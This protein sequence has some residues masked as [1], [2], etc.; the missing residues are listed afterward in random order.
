M[1]P[2]PRLCRRVS[3][4]RHRPISFAAV[5]IALGLVLA[6]CGAAASTGLKGP[7]SRASTT[8]VIEYVGGHWVPFTSAKPLSPAQWAV[9]D[10]YA[11][12]S[13]AALAV[14][15][16]RSVAPLAT[17]VSAQSKVT[18]M[19][20]RDL[21]A[22]KNPEAL[23]TKA[24]VESV[25][26]RG[27]RSK[28]TLEL[29]YPGGRSLHY[30]SSWVRP[31]DRAALAPAHAKHQIPGRTSPPGTSLAALAATQYA[32]WQFVGDNRV[33]GVDTPCGI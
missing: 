14:Y 13:S 27:C 29:Y 4:G 8:T 2:L 10:A 7:T 18:A 15:A 3:A 32:P 22:G 16:T 17:V 6:A 20:A 30:V 24:T 9:V 19:F 23:Y 26:I 33:G 31:F 11:N 12:F 25:A 5:L 1:A 21:A 28:L